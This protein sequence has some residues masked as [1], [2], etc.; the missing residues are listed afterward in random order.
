VHAEGPVVAVLPYYLGHHV[1]MITSTESNDYVL[2]FMDADDKGKL[3][4]VDTIN[5]AYH[6]QVLNLNPSIVL[7]P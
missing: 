2:W 3:S 7:P 5:F 4:A 1:K 6:E